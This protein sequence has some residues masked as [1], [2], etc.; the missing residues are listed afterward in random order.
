MRQS[1]LR[2]KYLRNKIITQVKHMPKDSYFWAG[3]LGVKDIIIRLGSFKIGD[4]T[5]VRFSGG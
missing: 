1:I 3:L 4:G 5:Q 2:N